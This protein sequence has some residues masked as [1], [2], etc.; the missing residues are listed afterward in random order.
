VPDGVMLHSRQELLAAP[1]V[2]SRLFPVHPGWQR[3]R[4]P[5]GPVH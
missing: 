2:P 1:R 5:A 4:P 3:W